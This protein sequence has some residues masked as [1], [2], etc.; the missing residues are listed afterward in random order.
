M[1]PTIRWDKW[2]FW[3][4]VIILGWMVASTLILGK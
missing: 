1:E 4:Q 3:V 2:G